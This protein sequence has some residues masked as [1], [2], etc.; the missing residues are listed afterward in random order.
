MMLSQVA[1]K[2]NPVHACTGARQ[3]SSCRWKCS[4]EDKGDLCV[5]G[6]GTG[7]TRRTWNGSQCGHILGFVQVL[8]SRPPCEWALE[9]PQYPP[10]AN[11]SLRARSYQCLFQMLAAWLG[12]LEKEENVFCSGN[13]SIIW[14]FWVKER[15]SLGLFSSLSL[16]HPQNPIIIK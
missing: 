7:A 8:K 16:H 3:L 13:Y 10:S 15:A 5:L 1:V 9:K 2:L 11:L 14:G 12:C 6:G 4:D